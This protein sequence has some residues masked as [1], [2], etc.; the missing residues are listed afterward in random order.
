MVA[1]QRDKRDS[2]SYRR[3]RKR[4]LHSGP[5]N[6][7]L[8][9]RRLTYDPADYLSPAAAQVDHVHPVAHGGTH[10]LDNMQIICRACNRAKSDRLPGST[11]TTTTSTR[12]TPTGCPPGPCTRCRGTHHSRPGV[13][14]ITSRTWTS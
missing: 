9:G 7:P 13:T 6:C 10:S 11:T 4:L 5:D 8:C 2:T 14:F 1:P 3:L 12:T